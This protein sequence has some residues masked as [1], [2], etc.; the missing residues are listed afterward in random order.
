MDPYKYNISQKRLE[1]QAL[2]CNGETKLSIVGVAS[3]K[4]SQLQLDRTPQ[5]H[6]YVPWYGILPTGVHGN[7]AI[8]LLSVN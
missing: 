1:I 2:R 6:V 3:M 4:T 5:V 8:L 7:I